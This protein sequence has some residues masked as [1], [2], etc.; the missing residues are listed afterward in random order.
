MERQGENGEGLALI[1]SSDACS[2]ECHRRN[3]QF[4][5]QFNIFFFIQEKQEGL[6]IFGTFVNSILLLKSSFIVIFLYPTYPGSF[7]ASNSST[8]LAK[9]FS[10]TATEKPTASTKQNEAKKTD[11]FILTSPLELEFST[12]GSLRAHCFY[13]SHS[14][15]IK[16]HFSLRH[17]IFDHEYRL[18]KLCKK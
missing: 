1:F 13:A 2:V 12:V 6:H 7:S 14:G 4:P 9:S 3:C 10:V 8:M 5:P 15:D 16:I 17:P 11:I 18:L